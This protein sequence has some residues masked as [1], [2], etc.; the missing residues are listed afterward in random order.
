MELTSPISF[1]TLYT[2][3]VSTSLEIEVHIGK[4]DVED[5]CVP[6]ELCHSELVSTK[7][8]Q[9]SYTRFGGCRPVPL[10]SKLYVGFY[11]NTIQ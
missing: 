1:L 5:Q 11:E 3:V 4:T 2:I 10:F 7:K 9:N 8:N 6:A